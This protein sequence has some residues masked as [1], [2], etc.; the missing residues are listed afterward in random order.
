VPADET[1]EAGKDGTPARPWTLAQATARIR[2]MASGTDHDLPFT[3]HALERM[4]QRDI[5]TFDVLAVLRHGFVHL[6]P[7]RGNRPGA[8]VYAMEARTP[9]HGGRTIRV[10][11]AVDPGRTRLK[12]VTVMFVDERG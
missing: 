11:V 2:A 5:S 12:V 3:R 7:V 1:T 6:A 4:D 9:D 10:V 8:F